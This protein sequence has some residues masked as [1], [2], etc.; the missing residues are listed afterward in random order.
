MICS[1]GSIGFTAVPRFI[2][3]STANCMKSPEISQVLVSCTYYL[4][5]TLF[6]GYIALPFILCKCIAVGNAMDAK[7][8]SFLSSR[9]SQVIVPPPPPSCEACARLCEAQLLNP[10]RSHEQLKMVTSC[11]SC[12]TCVVNASMSYDSGCYPTRQKI[13][14]RF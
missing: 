11:A 9:L 8:V 5:T 2:I 6:Y 10:A 7:A 3:L 4:L 13:V 14:T 12:H 1:V